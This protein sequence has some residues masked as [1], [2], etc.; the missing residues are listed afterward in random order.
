MDDFCFENLKIIY[1][2]IKIIVAKVNKSKYTGKFGFS[3]N[4]VVTNG[5]KYANKKIYSDVINN[6]IFHLKFIFRGINKY[7][8]KNITTDEILVIKRSRN[9]IILLNRN[10]VILFL[11]KISI[12]KYNITS[13]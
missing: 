13:S 12:I 11:L 1:I 8:R 3:S 5:A 6:I 10:S 9:I 4:S 7:V 2:F